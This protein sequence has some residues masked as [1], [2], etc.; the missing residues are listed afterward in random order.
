MVESVSTA[1]D[2]AMLRKL[3]PSARRPPRPGRENGIEPTVPSNPLVRLWSS[4]TIGLLL[5]PSSPWA[6]VLTWI[7]GA[8]ATH[9]RPLPEGMVL[10]C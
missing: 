2:A 8:L 6:V 1:T 4:E 9:V 3:L 5:G 7:L 10:H